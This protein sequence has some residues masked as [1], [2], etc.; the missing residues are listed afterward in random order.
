MNS[1]GY[2]VLRVY[3]QLS[4]RHNPANVKYKW[5]YLCCSFDLALVVNL[6]LL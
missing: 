6:V 3:N 2:V 5:L 4:N 1:V